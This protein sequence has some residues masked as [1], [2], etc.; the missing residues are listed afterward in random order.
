MALEDYNFVKYDEEKMTHLDR[1]LEGSVTTGSHFKKGVFP[2]SKSLIDY[3]LGSINDYEGKRMVKEVECDKIVGYDSLISLDNLS[4]NIKITREPRGK[5]EYL[6]NIVEGIDKTPTTDMVIVAGPLDE[7]EHG[8]YTIFPGK[9]A[10]SFPVTR[11]QLVE[12]G[13]EGQGL[14]DAVKQNK[15]YK[16]FW[17]NHG[18]V[19]EK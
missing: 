15:N 9:N 5:N 7:T 1:H 11:E 13:Y 10:P 17:D 14:E 2:N 19:K 6:V 16:E 18:F 12:F 4:E 8:F 3:A